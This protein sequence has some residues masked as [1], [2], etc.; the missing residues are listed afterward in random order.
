MKKSITKQENGTYKI[1]L[2]SS[3]KEEDKMFLKPLHEIKEIL[4][5]HFDE[6]VKEDYGENAYI[7]SIIDDSGLPYEICVQIN[8]EKK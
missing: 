3:T 8:I 4:H 6:K 7:S 1:T 2:T 5:Q